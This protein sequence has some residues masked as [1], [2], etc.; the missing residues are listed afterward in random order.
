MSDYQKKIDFAIKLLRSIPQD[1]EIELAYS[2]GKDSDVILELAKMSGIPFRAIYKNTTIDPPGTIA[3]CKSK[4]VEIRQPK[5]TFFELVR[6]NGLPNR[7]KRFCCGYLKEY[8]IKDRCIQGIRKSESKAR[9]ERYDEPEVCREYSKMDKVKIYY[10][11]LEWTDED[12]EQFII[13]R[14]IKVAPIYYD[15]NGIFHVERRLGCMGCPLAGKLKRRKF[16]KEYPKML[17]LYIKNFQIYLDTHKHTAMYDL[18][19]GSAYEK[20]FFDLF[21]RSQKDYEKK[22]NILFNNLFGDNPKKFLEDYFKIDLTI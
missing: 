2:G 19:K 5:K 6:E 11:I 4:G 13:E 14:N 9:A 15:K 3:H 17:R 1:G 12:V 10:P 16:F 8:K 20:M 21:C 22:Y 7:W 18:C